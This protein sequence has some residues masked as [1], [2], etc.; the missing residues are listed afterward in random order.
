[1]RKHPNKGGEGLSVAEP[2]RH[3]GRLEVH[4]KA[5]AL[6]A[7]TAHILANPKVFDP[8]VDTELISRIKCC[9]YD[10]YAKSWSANKIRA[11]TNGI[12]RISRYNLQE[13]SIL[14]CDEMMA[15]IGIAKAVFHLRKKRMAYWSKQIMEVRALLQAWKESDV[16][17]Y[18]QP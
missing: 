15:Y 17:H 10:I 6:A 12:N 18:G 1:M 3:K 13:E 16:K 8:N 9:A 5:Q 4:M 2:L 7:Y 11:E 14:L